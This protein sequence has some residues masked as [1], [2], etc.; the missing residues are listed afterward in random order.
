M[1]TNAELPGRSGRRIPAV[2]AA[3]L[4]ALVGFL[5]LSPLSRAADEGEA[6]S[7]TGTQRAERIIGVIA[8]RYEAADTYRI[9]FIQESYWALADT[10]YASS[11]TLLLRR[12]ATLAIS[13]D[14][15][16]RIVSDGESLWV[17]TSQTN[18]YFATRVRP[19]DIMLDPPTLLR[20][21]RIDPDGRFSEPTSCQ[22][23][24]PGGQSRTVVAISMKPDEGIS[25][26]A[27]LDVYIDENERTIVEVLARSLSGDFTRYRISRTVFDVPTES[28]SFRFDKPAGARRMG[29]SGSR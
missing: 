24:P 29:G 12:P 15:G 28:S 3:A 16:S 25:E 9:E 20:G 13:Y 5:V 4:L 26:P 11:G 19:E 27:G 1:R 14:D 7:E 10:L 17:Y 23:S 6:G 18:Q 2:P 22:L 21:Y 8:A